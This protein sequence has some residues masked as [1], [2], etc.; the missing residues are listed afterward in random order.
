M[1]ATLDV[2]DASSMQIN[3]WEMCPRP[4]VSQR[5][6]SSLQPRATPIVAPS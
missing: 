6:R 4:Q 3:L 2:C 1:K 5:V